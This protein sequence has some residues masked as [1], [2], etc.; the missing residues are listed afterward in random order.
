[1][2]LVG[3]M[4]PRVLERNKPKSKDFKFRKPDSTNKN[5]IRNKFPLHVMHV[6]LLITEQCSLKKGFLMLL[7][8]VLT[9]DQQEL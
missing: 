5:D 1:M 9:Q 2:H 7:Q 8:K 3:Y 4:T 6:D